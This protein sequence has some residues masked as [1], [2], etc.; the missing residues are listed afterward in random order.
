MKIKNSKFWAFSALCDAQESRCV[1]Y[2]SNPS[3][4]VE[5]EAFFVKFLSSILD[6]LDENQKFKIP[7]F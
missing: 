4:N 6:K 3:R 1:Q 7:G 5:Q 2:E